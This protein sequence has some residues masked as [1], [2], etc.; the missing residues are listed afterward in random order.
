[1]PGSLLRLLASAAGIAAAAAFECHSEGPILPRP[2]N[3]ANYKPFRDALANLTQLL[4]DSVT[5]RINAGWD[6]NNVSMSVGVISF[7]Q[8]D[9]TQPIW[10]FYRRAPNNVNGATTVDKN[11]QYLVGSI[12]KIISD[13]IL[14]KS[15]LNLDDPITKY[16]PV[17]NSSSSR[18]DWN[19]VSLRALASQLSGIP[20]NSRSLVMLL[21][22][23]P[24]C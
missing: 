14:L 15:G 1:M 23:K 8:P 13:L 22:R 16:I 7:D 2:A 19:T 11:S 20:P 6:H 4:N 12:S 10:E 21:H 9:P 3:I 17:L 5:G 24:T 18:I